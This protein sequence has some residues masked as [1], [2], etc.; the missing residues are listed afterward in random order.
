MLWEKVNIFEPYV[1]EYYTIHF[2]VGIDLERGKNI[3]LLAQEY[4][5]RR[6]IKLALELGVPLQIHSRNDEGKYLVFV[7]LFRYLLCHF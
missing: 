5:F 4:Q 7:P 6:F 3:S 2:K 1:L